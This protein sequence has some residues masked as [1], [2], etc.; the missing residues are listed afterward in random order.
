M[1]GERKNMCETLVNDMFPQLIIQPDKE[2]NLKNCL[3][4]FRL[5]MRVCAI[6]SGSGVER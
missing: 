1:R 3:F 4:I 6:S 5:I 2:S